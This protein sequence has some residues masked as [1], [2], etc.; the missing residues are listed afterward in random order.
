MGIKKCIKFTLA[1]VTQALGFKEESV[2]YYIHESSLSA[3]VY[4]CLDVGYLIRPFNYLEYIQS[5]HK[6]ISYYSEN[7]L[8]CL[9]LCLF[10][11]TLSVR[12]VMIRRRCLSVSKLLRKCVNLQHHKHLPSFI[13]YVTA[14]L[15]IM[16][17]I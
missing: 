8:Q 3:R 16:T 5:K 14:S 1:E 12:F 9:Q 17:S 10:L 4:T 7:F 6:G 11:T 15:R 13:I 2:G